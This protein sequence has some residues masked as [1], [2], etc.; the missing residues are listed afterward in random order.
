MNSKKFISGKRYAAKSCG[1][2]GDRVCSEAETTEL[3]NGQSMKGILSHAKELVFSPKENWE[4]M[5]NFEQENNTIRLVLQKH[6]SNYNVENEL[7]KYQRQGG[8]SGDYSI[9]SSKI[10]GRKP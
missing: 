2:D 1:G 5:N 8:E 7:K 10:H 9:S 4:L 6:H 3:C